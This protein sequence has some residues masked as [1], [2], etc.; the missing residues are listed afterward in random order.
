MRNPEATEPESPEPLDDPPAVRLASGYPP[1]LLKRRIPRPIFIAAISL[2]VVLRFWVCTFGYNYDVTSY[3]IVAGIVEAGD[4]VY[5]E[6]NRYNYGPVW[7][8]VIGLASRLAHAWDDEFGFFLLFLTSVL[9]L[10]DLALC[11][12]LKRRSGD[13]VAMFFFLNPVSIIISGYH[14]QFGNLALLMGLMAAGL[15]DHSAENRL[16]SRKWLGM[17]VLGLSLA[18][19]HLL[20]AFPFWLAVKQRRPLHRIVVLIVPAA[21]FLA[22]FIPYWK[23]GSQGIIDNVFLYRS[24][25]NA[26]FWFGLMPPLLS[27]RVPSILGFLAA[28]VIAG[29]LFRR[30]PAFES[31]LLYTAV[32]VVFSPAMAN[33]YLALAMPYVAWFLN[34]FGIAYAVGATLLLSVSADG[35]A[36]TDSVRLGWILTQGYAIVLTPLFLSLLWIFFHRQM[37][38]IVVRGSR[39][40]G[41]EIR[42]LLRT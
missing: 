36:I 12:L 1:A 28:L 9:T 17:V 25:H 26:P 16:D 37:A 40:F 34:P 23:S 31:A 14:R 30:L 22:S 20:F 19:K 41:R 39:W 2:G 27:S 21:I 38:T 13:G 10:T 8:H 5:A 6:T 7:L 4:N 35:L 33:Q 18:T 32:L 15:F 24:F 3:V 29:L 11:L 42:G